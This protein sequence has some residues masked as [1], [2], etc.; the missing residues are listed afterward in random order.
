MPYLILLA[1][2]AFEVLGT[3]LLKAT[4]GFTRL[5]PTV[6]C[7]GA[8]VAAFC[9]LAWA[10]KQ[11]LP[12]GVAY[13]MWAGLGTAAIVFAGAAEPVGPARV[14]CAKLHGMVSIQQCATPTNGLASASAS[15]PM[16]LSCARAPAR[17]GPST[18]ARD[19]CLRSMACLQMVG[20][21]RNPV[22]GR[23]YRREQVV[24]AKQGKFHVAR[25]RRLRVAPA[26]RHQWCPTAPLLVVTSRASFPSHR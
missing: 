16:P 18:S 26:A 23:C 10:I 8:Y 17:A 14:R 13:A 19:R 6:A 22:G 1:A 2:I 15:Y 3:S 9:A 20:F 5:W 25:G 7:L 12:V 11:E 4:D 24:I 21:H